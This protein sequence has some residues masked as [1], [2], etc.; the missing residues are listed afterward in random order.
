MTR[1]RRLAALPRGILLAAALAL[2][3]CGTGSV[4]PFLGERDVAFDARLVGTWKSAEGDETA[5]ITA[6]G[7]AYEIAYTDS[8]GRSGRFDAV[9]GRIGDLLVLDIV[10][11][12]PASEASESYRALL[13]PLHGALFVD[14]IE[15][16]LRVRL[17]DGD[18]LEKYLERRPRALEHRKVGD[19]VV[20]TAST[21]ELQ[22]FLRRYARRDDAFDDPGVW[23]RV[24]P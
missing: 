20:L 1:A 2:V 16:E 22:R 15:P 19:T 3:A 8:Q 23:R 17:L 4:A 21:A 5:E 24:A 10:P 18:A 13:L 6:D 9:L 7:S 14:S 12:D 11:S